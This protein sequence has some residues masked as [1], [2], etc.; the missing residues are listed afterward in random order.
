MTV[1]IFI[2]VLG[3]LVSV[4]ELGHF[5]AARNRG[6]KVEEFAF[7]FPPRIW[8]KKKGD[9]NYSINLIPLGGYVKL[10]G[11]HDED[12]KDPRSFASKSKLEQTFILLSGVAMNFLL[13]VFLLTI[14]YIFGVKSLIPGMEKHKGVQNNQEVKIIKVEKNTPAEKEGLKEG[15]IIKKVDGKQVFNDIEVLNVIN[16]KIFK[17]PDEKIVFEIKRGDETFTKDIE[18]YE[19]K[20]KDGNR[21]VTVRRIGIKELR[22]IG[23][24]K[25]P[26]YLAPFIA[27]SESIRLA[28]I[29]FV[30]TIDFFGNIFTKFALKDDVVG[31]IG[32]AKL[33]GTFM[34]FGLAALVQF[35][36][37]LSI[38]LAV[39]NILPI[40]AMDGG[41]IF[42]LLLEKIFG[43]DFSAQ[44][45]GMVAIVGLLML[46]LLFIIISVK[47]L[48]RFFNINLF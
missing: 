41:H 34:E 9:T 19:A 10:F 43:R 35:V 47:D 1:L 26:F 48:S 33:T 37:I 46:L 17:K 16:K 23:E 20:I 31:P 6:V 8:S 39:V 7:G 11:E 28:K 14:L 45:K 2:L 12:S 32:I 22:S 15:D 25:A 4:H 21:E 36:A 27:F 3:I 24:V 18:T 30:G 42:I 29:T 38:T 44:S 40:P 13:T 5:L